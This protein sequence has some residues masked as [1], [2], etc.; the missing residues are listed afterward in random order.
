MHM[1]IT[2]SY[3]TDPPQATGPLNDH[4]AMAELFPDQFEVTNFDGELV[5]PFYTYG[6]WLTNPNAVE[7]SIDKELMKILVRCLAAD[8]A[9]R[10]SLRELLRY[11][12]W[13]QTMP[14]WSE[15]QDELRAWSEEHISQA[16]IV[17]KKNAVNPSTMRC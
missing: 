4:D 1:L 17:R 12:R 16:P 9:D 13:R 14:D 11:A 8:P 15:G 2:H 10:P 7:A 3:W 6:I 5:D